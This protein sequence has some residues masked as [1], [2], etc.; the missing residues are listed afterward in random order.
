MAKCIEFGAD[1]FS[2]IVRKS[3][4]HLGKDGIVLHPQQHDSLLSILSGRDKIGW[5][6]SHI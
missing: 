5:E 1:S 4:Q 2:D 6:E 3:L